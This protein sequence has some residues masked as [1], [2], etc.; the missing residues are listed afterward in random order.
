[1]AQ[2]PLR[3]RIKERKIELQSKASSKTVQAPVGDV[4]LTIPHG[5]RSGQV[6]MFKPDSAGGLEWIDPV[7]VI[8]INPL[9]SKATGIGSSILSS[10]T[11]SDIRALLGLGSLATVTPSGTPDGSQFLRDDYSFQTI[12]HP[13]LNSYFPSGWL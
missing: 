3:R 2:T 9:I 11:A 6:L 5:G 10:K 8:P 7:T 12:S 13:Q 4:E 1:M